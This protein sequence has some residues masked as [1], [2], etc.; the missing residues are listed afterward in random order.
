MC[1]STL[2]ISFIIIDTL[3]TTQVPNLWMLYIS[4]VER[5][6]N[7]YLSYFITSFRTVQRKSLTFRLRFYIYLRTV[8]TFSMVYTSGWDFG[9]IESVTLKP[10]LFMFISFLFDVSNHGFGREKRS[11][12][13]SV[14]DLYW[15]N[16]NKLGD[17]YMFINKRFEAGLRL[18]HKRR[19]D[20]KRDLF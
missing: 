19:S 15:L 7:R 10:Y 17:K 4:I 20:I 2:L 13:K 16:V 1:V 6:C 8:R 9:V 11:L 3:C 5:V 18:E 14:K 12:I